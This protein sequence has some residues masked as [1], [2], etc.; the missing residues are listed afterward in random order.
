MAKL[1]VTKQPDPDEPE[2]SDELVHLEMELQ[3]HRDETS[4]HLDAMHNDMRSTLADFR[5][6]IAEE[7]RQQ[8]SSFAQSQLGPTVVTASLGQQHLQGVQGENRVRFGSVDP[9]ILPNQRLREESGSSSTLARSKGSTRMVSRTGG[10]DFI[11][12]LHR[13]VHSSDM[14]DFGE[15]SCGRSLDV[16]VGSQF[17]R[18][19]SVGRGKEIAGAVGNVVGLDFNA[20][21]YSPRGAGIGLQ[22]PP[23]F[24][25]TPFGLH[26]AGPYQ[27]ISVEYSTNKS[28]PHTNPNTNSTFTNS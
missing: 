6:S 2:V 4:A 22:G 5:S 1:Q 16:N 7:I 8:M 20:V 23:S 14:T 3:S 18:R 12:N 28:H 25:L 24:P 15:A 27:T 19:E 13:S 11:P 17:E 26:N 10:N 9:P 21:P